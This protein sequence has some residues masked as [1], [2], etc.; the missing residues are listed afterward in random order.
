MRGNEYNKWIA[1]ANTLSKI[2]RIAVNPSPLEFP[3]TFPVKAIGKD[4]GEFEAI[5]TDI[6]RRHVSELMDVTTRS[7][8]GGKYLA[9]TATFVAT[10]RD[11]LDALYRELSSNELVVMLL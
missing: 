6:L 5:V 1:T 3:C 9:V 8:A 4:T 10:S 7:S 11:Q 2:R